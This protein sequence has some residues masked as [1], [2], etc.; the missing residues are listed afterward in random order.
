MAALGVVDKSDVA[1]SMK[2]AGCLG[3][4]NEKNREAERKSLIHY[5]TQPL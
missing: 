2:L 5:S 3:N 4:F 1:I